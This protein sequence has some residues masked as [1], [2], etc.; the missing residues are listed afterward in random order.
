MGENNINQGKK[1]NS[2]L[3]S[4]NSLK[5]KKVRR[6]SSEFVGVRRK[7]EVP[8][9]FQKSYVRICLHFMVFKQFDV[10]LR[11]FWNPLHRFLM[12][13]AEKR[14]FSDQILRTNF[15]FGVFFLAEFIGVRRSSSE[16]AGVRRKRVFYWCFPVFMCFLTFFPNFLFFCNQIIPN[17]PRFC[18]SHIS[19]NICPFLL[20]IH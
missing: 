5:C 1:T 19:S 3:K 13:L 8:K 11:H 12:F 15:S 4:L 17:T 2:G 10:H 7:Q 14:R 6:S 9:I 16:F 18:H 20:S